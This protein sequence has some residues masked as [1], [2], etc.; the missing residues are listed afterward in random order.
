MDQIVIPESAHD[1]KD[2]AF[3]ATIERQS[4]PGSPREA[5]VLPQPRR[6]EINS[7]IIREEPELA[8]LLS[9]YT[10]EEIIK[11]LSKG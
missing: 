1:P 11:S 2:P 8:R 5:E 3:L 7:T 9:K 10:P 4:D 6:I